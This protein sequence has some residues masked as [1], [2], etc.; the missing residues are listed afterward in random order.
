[1]ALTLPIA[2]AAV[3]SDALCTHCGTLVPEHRKGRPGEAFCCA[4]CETLAAVFRG[5][6]LPQAANG[7]DYAYLDDAEFRRLYGAGDGAMD[8]YL[9]GVHCSACVWLVDRLPQAVPGVAS[10]ALDLSRSVAHVTVAPGGSLAEAARRLE[11]FGFRPH[12]VKDGDA[13]ILQKKENR[14]LLTR[15]GVAA[16]SVMN[17]MLFAI[18]LYSGAGKEWATYF[19][20]A[21][22]AFYL[23]I[24]FYS[25]VP[26]YASTFASLRARRMS[27]DVPIVIGIAVGTALGVRNLFHPG[28]IEEIY[29]DSLGTLV[30]LL[31]ASRYLVR[32]AQQKSLSSAQVV[33]RMMPAS[34]RR[35]A[36]ETGRYQTAAVEL[37]RA[38]DRVEV[39][40]GET[41]PADGVVL[42]GES[43]VNTAVLSG[44]TRPETVAPGAAVFAGTVNLSGVLQL[45]VQSSGAATRVGRIVKMVQDAAARRTPIANAADRVAFWFTFVVLLLGAV[46]LLVWWPAD[47]SAALNHLMALFIVTCPC[48]LAMSAPVASLVSMARAA[49]HGMLVKGPDVFEKLASASAIYLDKTGTLTEGDFGVLDFTVA[50]G[51]DAQ[52]VA[53]AALA[54]ERASA[55]PI[56]RAIVAHLVAQGAPELAADDVRETLGTGVSGVVAGRRYA[57]R[58]LDAPEAGGEVVT[59]IAVFEDDRRVAVVRLGDRVRAGA[60]GAVAAL[61][62]AGFDVHLLSG[63]NAAAARAAA[64]AVGIEAANVHAGASPEDKLAVMK[65]APAAVMVGDGANDSAALAAA[66]V[67]VAV[68]GGME[69]S[70]RAADAYFLKPG[71]DALPRLVAGARET[72]AVIYRNFGFSLVY[73]IIGAA[74]AMSGHMSPL[75]AAVLMPISSFTILASSVWGS[76]SLR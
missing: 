43:E 48:A 19:A 68:H 41:F 8:F 36:P 2:A 25:A 46:T 1:M 7:D 40:A 51:A 62:A 69:V 17:L 58:R 57:L 63:D 30:F 37:L 76:R 9:E 29:F 53:G 73:N 12:A 28:Q 14:K 21:S 60:A 26:F 56:A 31:L 52:A 18:A 44:E 54:L 70:L 38:G 34:C 39:R 23:P 61:R 24:V 75:V 64:E 10:A 6:S 59:S 49:K 27:I 11:S 74:A 5:A 50:P 42:A 13:E 66:R 32:R 3:S 33:F 15:L 67:G 22:F 35:L 20:W 47:S 4:G 45:E 55:H 65:A 16:A 72:V 71:V